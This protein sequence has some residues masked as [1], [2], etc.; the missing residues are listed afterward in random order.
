MNLFIEFSLVGQTQT[1]VQMPKSGMLGF[2][3]PAYQSFIRAGVP[4]PSETSVKG[5]MGGALL[6]FRCMYYTL[7]I[8]T[9]ILR[10]SNKTQLLLFIFLFMAASVQGHLY[11]PDS[12]IVDTM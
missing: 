11:N 3:A 8:R 2:Y 5:A 12:Q 9:T 6:S 7:G 10:Q 4:E 1:H